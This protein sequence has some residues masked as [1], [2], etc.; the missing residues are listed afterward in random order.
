[1]KSLSADI[2]LSEENEHYMYDRNLP[3][4][5]CSP[6]KICNP[7]VEVSN[8]CSYI[9]SV[10]VQPGML[11]R[12]IKTPPDIEINLNFD[13]S[14]VPFSFECWLQGNIDY[15]YTGENG[16]TGKDSCS[17][18]NIIF[19]SAGKEKGFAQ[20][21]RGTAI[22]IVQLMMDPSVLHMTIQEN[23]KGFENKFDWDKYKGG[24]E[25]R[26][27]S[28]PMPS[29]VL[30]IAKSISE[31][32]ISQ[33]M[34]NF[35][36]ANKAQELFYTIIMELLIA[37]PKKTTS[38]IQPE[39]IDKFDNIK[40]YIEENLSETLSHSKLARCAGI[41]EFKLKTGFKE[42]YGT[43]VYGYI[44]KKRMEKAKSLLESG[45]YSVSDA[46]WH[47]GYTNVSHFISSFKKHHNITPGKFL[48]SIKNRFKSCYHNSI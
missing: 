34:R 37:K 27:V 31:C 16:I 28:T 23:L 33:P 6:K 38:C 25:N 43:T 22:E 10:Q 45:S 47:L 20:K 19:G 21:K 44:I 42:L 8:L 9:E 36:L 12:V 5:S 3:F 35:A 13:V 4:E 1:M 29:S 15:H 18:G 32:S 7:C 39:D 30:S 48:S 17:E 41:N 24:A 26:F 14:K 40:N 11:L 46:A 2:C